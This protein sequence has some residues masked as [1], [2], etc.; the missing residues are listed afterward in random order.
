MFL[1]FPK[2]HLG[3]QACKFFTVNY[4]LCGEAGCRGDG[5]KGQSRRE[6]DTDISRGII[7]VYLTQV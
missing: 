3:W 2:F 4:E 1:A 6:C 5:G 7:C